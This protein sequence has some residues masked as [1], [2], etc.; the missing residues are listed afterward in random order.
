MDTLAVFGLEQFSVY[1]TH[2]SA[3]HLVTIIG[4]YNGYYSYVTHNSV[5][6]FTTVSALI[7]ERFN[8]HGIGGSAAICIC[9]SSPAMTLNVWM[10]YNAHGHTYKF[11]NVTSVKMENLQNMNPAKLQQIF[12]WDLLE[13]PP[14]DQCYMYFVMHSIFSGNQVFRT[15]DEAVEIQD[16]SPQRAAISSFRFPLHFTGTNWLLDNAGGGL[17]AMGTVVRVDGSLLV[18]NNTASYGGGIHLEDLCL[19]QPCLCLHT[20]MVAAHVL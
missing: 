18:H 9:K 5:L 19:V 16:N 13:P 14:F 3:A 15:E 8:V 7:L 11:N 4:L 20:Y 10:L 1:C 6:T 12:A 2:Q 17:S